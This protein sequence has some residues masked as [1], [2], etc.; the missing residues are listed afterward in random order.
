LKVLRRVL[1]LMALAGLAMTLRVLQLRRR[2][3]GV[4]ADGARVLDLGSADAMGR[5]GLTGGPTGRSGPVRTAG[6]WPSDTLVAVASVA[7]A[8]PTTRWVPAVD[9]TCPPGY[10]VKVS[11]T[12]IVHVPGGLSYL[13]TVPERCYATAAEAEADGY[14]AAKR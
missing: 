14:R 10:P 6:L 11:R 8:E 9:G 4:G 13:R 12:G 5:A 1:L 3:S 7:T 2:M